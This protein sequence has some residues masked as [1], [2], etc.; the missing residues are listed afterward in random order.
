VFGAAAVGWNGLFLAEVA[1]FSPRGK[2]SVATSAAMTWNFAGILIGPALFATVFNWVD[3]YAITYGA[4][5]LVAA[6]AVA[7]F[8]RC[9]A[10]A[11]RI[12][13]AG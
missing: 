10:A 8:G 3:S 1:R 12:A 9:E 7:A 13:P 5:S 2:V 11:R 6:A 4:L